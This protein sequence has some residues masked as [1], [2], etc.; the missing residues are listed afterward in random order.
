MELAHDFLQHAGQPESLIEAV[1]AAIAKA[2][3]PAPD[4]LPQEILHDALL[5]PIA[6]KSFLQ[7]AELYRLEHE[8]R[9]GE[10]IPDVEWTRRCIGFLDSHQF[11]TRYAHVEYNRRRAANLV[12]LHKRLREQEEKAVRRKVDDARFSR[13]VGRTVED[14]WSIQT[15]EEI[16]LL[17]IM[18][19]RTST[20]IHVNAIMMSLVVAILVRKL[21][22][23]P[24]LIVPTLVLLTANVVTIFI[25][26]FSLRAGRAANKRLFGNDLALHDANPLVFA[27]PRDESLTEFTQRMGALAQDADALKKSMLEQLYFGRKFIIARVKKLR[28]TYD[29]FIYG[30]LLSLV[31]FAISLSR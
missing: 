31:V 28:L 8:R 6:S 5:L 29:V 18:D 20:M 26:V 17:A 23:H 11:R 9:T 22:E 24:R 15:R 4:D 21:D 1:G 19:K 16:R 30:L 13:A 3:S 25:S 2:Q 14:I 27:T 7:D 10:V 12:R